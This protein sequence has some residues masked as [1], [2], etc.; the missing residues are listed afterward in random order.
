[1]STTPEQ[2]ADL[3]KAHVDAHQDLLD[4]S[5]SLDSRVAAKEEKV[6]RFLEEAPQNFI[7]SPP[8]NSNAFL[9]G[10]AAGY[11]STGNVTVTAAHPYTRG[12]EGPYTESKGSATAANEEAATQT[13]PYYFG[14]YNKGPRAQRGGIA[15]GWQG[16]SNG[17]ILKLTKP[18]GGAHPYNNACV[19]TLRHHVKL[20]KYIFRAYVW[21]Q[22]GPLSFGFGPYNSGA[23]IIVPSAKEWHPINQV[24]QSSEVTTKDNWRI[25]LKSDDEQEIYIAMMNI[26][27]VEGAGNGFSLM[28]MD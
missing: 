1:M 20:H 18:A 25:R 23:N 27:A 6:E 24:I 11:G 21:V 19:F 17:H 13:T 3:T 9:I 10:G 7:L 28:N 5:S 4:F 12:F 16:I 15:G 8:L 14:R 26:F 2:I 22:S